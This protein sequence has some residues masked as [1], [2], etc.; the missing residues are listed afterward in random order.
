MGMRRAF[1]FS[2]FV[3]FECRVFQKAHP[4]ATC[5]GR[6]NVCWVEG[7][8]DKPLTT[9]GHCGGS[10][11]ELFRQKKIRRVRRK[12]SEHDAV[13]DGRPRTSSRE[14]IEERRGSRPSWPR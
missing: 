7:A 9:V 3:Y 2:F 11:S 1:R 6:G 13:A 5:G 14:S 10:E 8:W 12:T 4:G